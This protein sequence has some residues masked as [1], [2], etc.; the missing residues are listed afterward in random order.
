M[1]LVKNTRKVSFSVKISNS[2]NDKLQRVKQTAA[3]RGMTFSLSQE[4]E[5]LIEREVKKAEKDL[6]LTQDA[7]E[8]K[9]QGEL[10]LEGDKTSTQK[11]PTAKS[12]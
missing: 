8:A 10:E 6:G 4:V 1:A 11:K 2:L 7:T 5:N 3:D 12:K 9:N